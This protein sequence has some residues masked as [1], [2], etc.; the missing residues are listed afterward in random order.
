MIKRTLFVILPL[1][2]LIA[3]AANLRSSKAADAEPS[4]KAPTT[5]GLIAGPGRVEALSEEIKVG[6]QITGKIKYVRVE[7]GAKVRKGQILAI[8]EF[9]DS[10]AQCA[11]AEAT[12][13]QKQAE[14][15]KVNNGARD[16]ERRE[17]AAAVAEAEA[18]LKNAAAEVKRREGLF[19]DGVIARDATDMAIREHGVAVARLDAA[20]Q[21]FALV[22]D[23]AREE[24]R[25]K[26]EADVALARAQVE[27]ARAEWEKHFV[28][29]PISGTILRKHVRAGETVSEMRDTP[30]ITLADASVLRVRMDVDE[31][32]VSKIHVGQNAYVTAD[33]Y[34]GKKF[35]GKVVRVGS[36]LG[37]KNV[38]TDEPTERIDNKIL[39]TLI[40]LAPGAQLPLGLRVDAFLVK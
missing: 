33:A 7:E 6:A 26:A 22:D 31:A 40:E 8:L 14:L 1:A 5:T 29:A 25:A 2:V 4:G 27:Q 24:D 19:K 16:M 37:R 39:E 36:L 18:V 20:K 23:K 13:L 12:L 17:A 38:H 34:P 21:H 9:D 30:V 15:R 10:M 35:S 32:D 3:V 11:S 28:R